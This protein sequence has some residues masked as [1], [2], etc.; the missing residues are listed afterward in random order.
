[1]IISHVAGTVDLIWANNNPYLPSYYYYYYYYS[2]FRYDRYGGQ[3]PGITKPLCGPPLHP[4]LRVL[5]L[6]PSTSH[7]AGALVHDDCS[8]EDHAE[9]H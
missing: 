8:G 9:Y 2:S 1:M 3:D 6:P 7:D 5:P 4:V